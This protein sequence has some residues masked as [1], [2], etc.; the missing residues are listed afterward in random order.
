MKKEYDLIVYIGRFQPFHIAHQKTIEHALSISDKVLVLIG[1][2][3]GPRSIKNPFTYD[4]R[5]L[6]IRQSFEPDANLIISP[7]GDH[8]YDDNAWIAEVGATVGL[9]AQIHNSEKIGIIGNRKDSSSFYLNYFKHWDFIEE[10]LY[11]ED[12]ESIDATKIRRLLFTGDHHFAKGVITDNVY[13]YLCSFLITPEYA[14]L[15]QEWV[16]VQSYLAAWAGA[17]YAPTFVTVDAVV[18]QSGHV[19]LVRRAGYPGRGL[20]AIPGGF[21]DPDER[22]EKAV[23]RE[24]H[25]ETGLKLPE[26]VLHRAIDAREVFDSPTRSTR[27]R[28][29]THAFRMTLDPTQSLPKVKGDGSETFEARWFTLSEFKGME[30]V[31][32]EDHFHIINTMLALPTK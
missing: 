6:M 21:V 7:I 13:D 10:P 26:K 16:F 3:H 17:P 5:K 24:L 4:E 20:W 23:T 18:V 22:I 25:E 14:E 8:T 2:P 11:P 1:S 30:N 12:G 15:K 9:V 29:I 32:Y 28:T 31:M 27:G 19:L